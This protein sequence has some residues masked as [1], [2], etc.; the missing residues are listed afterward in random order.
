M[1]WTQ[2]SNSWMMLSLQS[3]LR[4]YTVAGV[5]LI[6][7][8][9]RIV[10]RLWWTLL[11]PCSF[12][13][14]CACKHTLK[15]T[16]THTHTHTHTHID[17][18]LFCIQGGNQSEAFS[19]WTREGKR[20]VQGQTLAAYLTAGSWAN[21]EML[22]WCLVLLMTEAFPL[23]IAFPHAFAKI[24]TYL[25]SHWPV[26]KSIHNRSDECSYNFMDIATM[27]VQLDPLYV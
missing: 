21:K 8:I 20:S 23:W 14:K 27:Q 25:W 1:Y 10:K 4:M 7:T 22:P 11:G 19:G 18:Q 12:V 13:C 17:A 6:R 2:D 24:F 16:N 3:F 5:S 26:F 15:P 9:G